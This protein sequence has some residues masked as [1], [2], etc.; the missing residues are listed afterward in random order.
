[1]KNVNFTDYHYRELFEDFLEIG[2]DDLEY[3]DLKIK[4]LKHRFDSQTSEKGENKNV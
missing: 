4:E 3:I 2:I 1:M